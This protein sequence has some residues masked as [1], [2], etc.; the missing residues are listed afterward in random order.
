MLPPTPTRALVLSLAL[1]AQAAAGP[2]AS[3][4]RGLVFT[5][6][7]SS[8]QDNLI[9]A[10]QPSDLTWY[11]NYQEIPS[12]V[13]DNVSQ[14]AF[15]FVPMMWGKPDDISD[16]AF[17]KTVKQLVQDRGVNISHALAFNEPDGPAVY[18]GSNIDPAVAAQIWVNNF[19][20]LRKLGIRVGLP[21]CTGAPAGLTWLKDFLKSCS[22]IV[23]DGG[24]TKNCT[25]DFVP[26][27]WYGNFEG[28]ASHMG[29]YAAAFPNKT[30]WLTEYN[31]NH[32]DLASTQS[33][34]NTSAEYMDR[35]PLVERY[36]LFGA[37]RSDVSN[38]G[39]NAAM[40]SAGGELTDIGAWYLG[41]PG[42]GV[43][44]T[45]GGG[46]FRA[47]GCHVTAALAG[48]LFATAA[49]LLSF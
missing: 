45:S 21:A 7:S 22:E 5:P 40:L 12:P 14:S 20:P 31:L 46:A 25:F 49:A 24:P 8:P 2:L 34:Y 27:H 23:S 4:K 15:E 38:V 30:M 32:Q 26:L 37:F 42:T 1:V 10:S 39:P 29:E 44:P 36:S 35:L 9:W 3:S 6:N 13:F 18:G 11:Y 17:L 47:S 41:R 28:L 43:H 19:E 33:F 16:T 48:T